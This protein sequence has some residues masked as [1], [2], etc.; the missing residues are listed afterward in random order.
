MALGIPANK[1]M[2]M[3]RSGSARAA[4]FLLSAQAD[5]ILIRAS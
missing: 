3:D 5:A 4:P 1:Q 2:L